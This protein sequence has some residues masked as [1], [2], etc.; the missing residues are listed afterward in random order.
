MMTVMFGLIAVCLAIPVAA[1]A[2]VG[3]AV[4]SLG[5]AELRLRVR[6]WREVRDALKRASA[7]PVATMLRL[8]RH[9]RKA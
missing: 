4:G 1:L 5:L 3:W 8:P 7:S 2:C 9:D 6:A